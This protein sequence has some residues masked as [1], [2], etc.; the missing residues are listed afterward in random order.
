MPPLK[1]EQQ[2]T[3]MAIIE[4]ALFLSRD[5]L[6]L[7]QLKIICAVNV[8]EIRYSLEKI[9]RELEKNERG[10]ILLETPQGYRLGTKPET[11]V[12]LE[13]VRETENTGTSLSQAALETLAI[14]ALK[15]PVTR[16]EIENIRGVNAG[17]ILENLLNRNLISITGRKESLGRPLLYG[18]TE[19]FMQYF[20]LKELEELENELKTLI[21]NQ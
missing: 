13:Q 1:T 20:G 12:Y 3:T 11:A 17:G 10:L 6:S 5:P 2:L 16:M 15:Q 8:K 21:S 4:A 18:V 9:K 7:E 19:I 14:I